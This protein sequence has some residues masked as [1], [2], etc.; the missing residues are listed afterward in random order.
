MLPSLYPSFC[1]FPRELWNSNSKGGSS[2]DHD[3]DTAPTDLTASKHSFLCSPY[4]HLA[5][6]RA[7]HLLTNFIHHQQ[8]E[9]RQC[10]A[11][12]RNGLEKELQSD[13]WV[14]ISACTQLY[15]YKIL[16]LYAPTMKLLTGVNIVLVYHRPDATDFFFQLIL[17]DFIIYRIVQT[18]CEIYFIPLISF[19]DTICECKQFKGTT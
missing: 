19:Q 11:K 1:P 9:R 8:L 10:V 12:T 17:I 16:S 2:I 15:C 13:G 18:T 3:H 4:K 7:N 6:H 14:S 5:F